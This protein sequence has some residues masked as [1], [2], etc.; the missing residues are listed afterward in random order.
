[1][2]QSQPTTT[3]IKL[4]EKK[5]KERAPKIKSV[6]MRASERQLSVGMAILRTSVMQKHLWMV[7][8]G[9]EQ[10]FHHHHLNVSCIRID[11]VSFPHLF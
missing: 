5:G 8:G 9:F 7:A 10:R 6:C 11:P 2:S 4:E 3:I 1:M